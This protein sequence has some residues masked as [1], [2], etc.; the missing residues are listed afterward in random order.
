MPSKKKTNASQKPRYRIVSSVNTIMLAVSASMVQIK[1]RYGNPAMMPTV[2]ITI[3]ERAV[4]PAEISVYY[5]NANIGCD[6]QYRRLPISLFVDGI[7]TMLTQ[8]LGQNVH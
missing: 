7:K 6:Q 4:I 3:S 2:L 5:G 1:Y 8:L